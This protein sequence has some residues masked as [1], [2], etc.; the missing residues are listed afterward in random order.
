ME[1]VELR[2][3]AFLVVL[4]MGEKQFHYLGVKLKKNVF[5]RNPSLVYFTLDRQWDSEAKVLMVFRELMGSK[6]IISLV[7]Y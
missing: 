2:G 7:P 1:E 5:K 4:F 3:D 6:E